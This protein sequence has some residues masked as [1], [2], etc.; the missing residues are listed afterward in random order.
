MKSQKIHEKHIFYSNYLQQFKLTSMIRFKEVAEGLIIE[1]TD[2]E[3]LLREYPDLEVGLYEV[4]EYSDFAPEET[5][6]EQWSDISGS[7]G[8]AAVGHGI[9]EYGVGE[10]G[11]LQDVPFRMFG[12]PEVKVGEILKTLVEEG[13]LLFTPFEFKTAKEL[14]G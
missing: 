13:Q 8:H 4:M 10:L 14:E 3:L 6:A 9:I 1:V 12:S 7:I 2:K 11:F 5:E